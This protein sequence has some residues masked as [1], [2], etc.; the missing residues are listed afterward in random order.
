MRNTLLAYTTIA[1]LSA[2]GCGKSSPSETGAAPAPS[3]AVA[4]SA[5]AAAGSL[6]EP[7]RTPVA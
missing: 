6:P 5:S 2:V 1:A 3:A 4:D 7:P